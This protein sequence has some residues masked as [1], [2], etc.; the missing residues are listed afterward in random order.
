VVDLY[1]EDLSAAVQQEHPFLAVAFYSPGCGRCRRL[2]PSWSQAAQLLKDQNLPI[3]LARIDISS[4]GGMVAWKALGL[5]RVPAVFVGKNSD[6]PLP[7]TGHLDAGG[8]A[9]HLAMLERVR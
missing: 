7:Y 8:I 3:R 6:E 9:A 5:K 2:L 4:R 1:F